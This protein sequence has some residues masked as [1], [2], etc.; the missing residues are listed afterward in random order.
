ME[1]LFVAEPIIFSLFRFA[2][3]R[4]V[5]NMDIFD[6]LGLDLEH[7]LSGKT[8]SA[9]L[10]FLPYAKAY[11]YI[12]HKTQDK[13]LGLHLGEQYNIAALGV[14]GQIISV[15]RNIKEAIEKAQAHFNLISN[16]LNLA[17]EYGPKTF[18]LI[19]QLNHSCLKQ[20]PIASKH[21]L[22]SSMV[23]AY[24]ELKFLIHESF[25]PVS[26]NFIFNT[27]S[28]KEYRRIFGC[29]PSFN[30]KFNVLEFSNILLSQK[31]L[32]ADYELLMILEK[33][34]CR[35]L[36]SLKPGH[37]LKSQIESLIYSLLNPTFPS[38]YDI[39]SNLNMSERTLQRKLMEEGT[40][41]SKITEGI[42]KDLALKY[43]RKDISIKEVS[44]M[45]GYSEPASFVNA[46]KKWFGSTPLTYR[47]SHF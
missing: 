19:F 9:A 28:P 46:F 30:T 16:V 2:R 36:A 27:E 13:E 24:Q 5:T 1:N 29:L 22:T 32:Y 38:F 26:A 43:L 4:G 44:Y 21:L 47:S 35:R 8:K 25:N 20:T 6:S 40:S 23:F 14:V 41:Y 37:D 17:I 42:K 12:E 3:Q 11:E 7:G 45:M 34:A 31:V 18:K 15:S 33:E 39:A 10:A